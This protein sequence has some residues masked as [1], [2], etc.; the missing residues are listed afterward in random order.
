[1]NFDL[2]QMAREDFSNQII[3]LP[4]NL[5]IREKKDTASPFE[6][7]YFLNQNMSLG[8]ETSLLQDSTVKEEASFY[9]IRNIHSIDDIKCNSEY[10]VSK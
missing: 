9:A 5:P 6:C 7:G 2:F 8:G 10:G 4:F 1:M 3:N